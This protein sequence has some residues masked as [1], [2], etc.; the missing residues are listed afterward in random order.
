MEPGNGILL[1]R[2]SQII[3]NLGWER[4]LSKMKQE[5]GGGAST[6]TQAG[7]AHLEPTQNTRRDT[8]PQGSIASRA[9]L[10]RREGPT[11]AGPAGHVEHCTGRE[12]GP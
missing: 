11:R 7:A 5:I 12:L 10:G 9:S 3:G 1:Y 8:R 6:K 4:D 2:S